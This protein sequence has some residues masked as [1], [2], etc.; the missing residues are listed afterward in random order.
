V[1][2]GEHE[3]PVEDGAAAEG[4]RIVDVLQRDL[5]EMMRWKSNLKI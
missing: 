4:L 2:S 3:V 5:C 1:G